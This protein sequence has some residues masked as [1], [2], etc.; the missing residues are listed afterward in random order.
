MRDHYKCRQCTQ[1]SRYRTIMW[2]LTLCWSLSSCTVLICLDSCYYSLT[3]LVFEC[4]VHRFRRW[5][6]TCLVTVTNVHTHMVA[7]L[8]LSSA[9]II[10]KE[11][12]RLNAFREKVFDCS[13][14]VEKF[15][16]KL[17]WFVVF[18][19]SFNICWLLLKP[20]VQDNTVLFA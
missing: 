13:W 12:D 19:L 3:C 7:Q 10:L 17:V 20:S 15:I 4:A 18:L 8:I 2:W 16:Q 5:W 1:Q 9:E 14:S 11:P 6:R